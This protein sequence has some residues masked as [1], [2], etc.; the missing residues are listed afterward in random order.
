LGLIRLR[1]ERGQRRAGPF[2]LSEERESGLRGR[3]KVVE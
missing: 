1:G 2:D 3:E